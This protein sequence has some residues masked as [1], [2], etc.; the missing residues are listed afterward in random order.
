MYVCHLREVPPSKMG[1]PE[2]KMA[3]SIRVE[4]DFRKSDEKI[5][6]IHVNG[7]RYDHQWRLP[8]DVD[9]WHFGVSLMKMGAWVEI[10]FPL[11]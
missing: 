1:F 10:H 7:Y 9:E 5:M 6:E 2:I 11:N 4:C 8:N 3:H